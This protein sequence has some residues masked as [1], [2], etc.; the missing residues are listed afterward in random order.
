MSCSWELGPEPPLKI[1][2]FPESG[3][4]LE[5]RRQQVAL[6]DRAWPADEPSSPAPWH[7]PA[8]QAFSMLLLVDDRVVA[9]LDVLTR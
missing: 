3:V 9:A 6:Q 7:D 5:L 2:C 1:V 8:L 4:P